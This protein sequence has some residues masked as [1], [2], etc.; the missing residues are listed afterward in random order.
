MQSLL[1]QD[2]AGQISAKL[3]RIAV[4]KTLSKLADVLRPV[5]GEQRASL[6]TASLSRMLDNCRSAIAQ[7]H[8]R[9]TRETSHCKAQLYSISSWQRPRRRGCDVCTHRPSKK[10]L[11]VSLW[12]ACLAT[13]PQPTQIPQQPRPWPTRQHPH[14]GAQRHFAIS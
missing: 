9:T 12:P 8:H 11:P 4:N 3:G 1:G 13:M 5:R 10:L 7:H 6:H 14:A 2:A